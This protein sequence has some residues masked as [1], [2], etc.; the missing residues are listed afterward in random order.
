MILLLSTIANNLQNSQHNNTEAIPIS[1]PAFSPTPSIVRVNIFLFISLILSLATVLIGIVSLQWL[2]EH[3][4]HTGSFTPQNTFAAVHMRSE[5]L[6]KWRVPEVFS[7]LPLILQSALI[8]FFVGV[9][10]FLL[11]IDTRVVIPVAIV[12]GLTLVFLLLTTM[13]PTLQAF[14]LYHPYL[15][16]NDEVPVQCPYKS[17]QSR[18]FRRLIT[19]SKVIFIATSFTFAM[20]Y[21]ISM[22]LC[23]LPG[24]IFHSPFYQSIWQSFMRMIHKLPTI[25][26]SSSH[27]SPF[28]ALLRLN[29]SKPWDAFDYMTR[30]IYGFWSV[31]SSFDFDLVWL[32]VRDNYFQST[33]SPDSWLYQ[34]RFEHQDHGAIYD[35]IMGLCEE[36]TKDDVNMN[37]DFESPI[38][39]AY[40][41]AIDPSSFN[42]L[43]GDE[44]IN[45]ARTRNAY[46]TTLLGYN[47]LTPLSPFPNTIQNHTLSLLW[48][49]NAFVLLNFAYSKLYDLDLSS[50]RLSRHL[51]E[52]SFRFFGFLYSQPHLTHMLNGSEDGPPE[53]LFAADE[54]YVMKIFDSKDQRECTCSPLLIMVNADLSSHDRYDQRLPPNGLSPLIYTLGLLVAQMLSRSTLKVAST[55]IDLFGS[56]Y[57][58]F[59]KKSTV[60]SP[61]RTFIPTH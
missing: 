10:E 49:E 6:E 9:I 24:Q 30:H 4:A 11:N 61:T 55:G 17:P 52:I 39:T 59:G 50:P 35:A 57:G 56:T 28:F 51:A 14:I 12:I 32:S 36:L 47:Q 26:L 29:Q 8:L 18:A 33:C 41:C 58:T 5:A 37:A 45:A 54:L 25:N 31:K 15:K 42:Q 3:Q 46:L 38:F 48:E 22:R 27:Q 7:A 1:Q 19:S 43:R 20:I 23:L 40:H 21:W 34:N 53:V 13:L 2:R 16:L 44:Q 60:N